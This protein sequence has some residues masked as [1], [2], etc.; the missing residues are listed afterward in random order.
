M[1]ALGEVFE[2]ELDDWGAVAI[3]ELMEVGVDVDIE[4]EGRKIAKPV[5][6]ATSLDGRIGVCS[7]QFV[8]RSDDGRNRRCEQARMMV[9]RDG[10][11]DPTEAE[12]L[13]AIQRRNERAL[14]R[15]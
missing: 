13:P 11:G 3:D 9:A 6:G 14:R 1:T 10:H 12:S 15:R 2:P 7:I 8:S 4:N 5:D